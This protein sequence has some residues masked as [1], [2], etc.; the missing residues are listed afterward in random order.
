M[1]DSAPAPRGGATDDIDGN[2]R[3]FRLVKNDWVKVNLSPPR[4]S[5]QAFQ[6]RQESGAMSVYLED[7]I[8]SAGRS[9]A[10]LQKL[11]EGYW[12]FSLT[13]NQLRAE[14]DQEVVRDPQPDF[15][16]HALVRDRS[17]KRSQGKRSRMASVCILV[18]QPGMIPP[19]DQAPQPLS[20]ES[21]NIER[22]TVTRRLGRRVLGWISRTWLDK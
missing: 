21:R 6:D 19:D 12:V 4:P 13:V 10:E 3:T 9:L 16:G 22:P 11:W 15:P 20:E 1:E 5:S 14:F 18:L 2:C 8:N 17:G 7:E